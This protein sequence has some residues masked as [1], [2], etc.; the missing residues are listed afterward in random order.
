MD[1]NEEDESISYFSLVRDI[2]S[3]FVNKIFYN[4]IYYF[5][6][7]L[8]LFIHNVSDLLFVIHNNWNTVLDF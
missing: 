3:N 1:E 5:K 7:Y 2:F 6:Q 8:D 4:F